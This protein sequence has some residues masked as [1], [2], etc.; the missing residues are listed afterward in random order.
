MK[1][2]KTAYDLVVIIDCLSDIERKKYDDAGVLATQLAASGIENRYYS[3]AGRA[4]VFELLDRLQVEAQAG[5]K[6]PLVFISH[7]KTLALYIKHESEDIEWHE[8]R[9]PLNE[10]NK[11]MQ[12]DLLVLMS[13]CNGFQGYKIDKR[14]S[15]DEAFFGIIGPNR[16]IDPEESIQANKVFFASMI[17][18]PD[19]VKAVNAINEDIGDEVYEAM[20]S[21]DNKLS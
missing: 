7:G 21:Q 15:K 4:S 18:D 1:K 10:I 2:L 19:V 17:R 8:L 16:S 5:K 9:A 11:A 20:T 12:G 13:C 14:D 3:C 6:F